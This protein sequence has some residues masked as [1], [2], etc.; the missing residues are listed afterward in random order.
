[1]SPNILTIAYPETNRMLQLKDNDFR[2]DKKDKIQLV[3]I[4]IISKV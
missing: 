3:F 1:M 4:R 2:P